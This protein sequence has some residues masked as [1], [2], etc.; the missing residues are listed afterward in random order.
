MD[1]IGWFESFEQIAFSTEVAQLVEYILAMD[2]VESSSLFFRIFKKRKVILC[3]MKVN[4][5][6]V[7]D[8][9]FRKSVYNDKIGQTGI[10]RGCIIRVYW[11]SNY[12]LRKY[13]SF[14]GLCLFYRKRS[15]YLSLLVKLQ[16]VPVILCIPIRSRLVKSVEVLKKAF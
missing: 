5:F 10:R 13:Q 15:S 4:F 8:R 11:F 6:G 9:N 16:N 7:F 1:G 2:L 12:K 14:T 3:N